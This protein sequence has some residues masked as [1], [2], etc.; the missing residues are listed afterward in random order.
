MRPAGERPGS[1][2]ETFVALD[3]ETAD[4]GRDSACA[5]GIVRVENRRIVQSESRL[6]RPPRRDFVFTPI[7]GIRWDDVALAPRFD[8]VWPELRGLVEGA[9]FLAAHNA[10]FDRSV[11][12]ACCQRAGLSPPSIPFECTVRIARRVW[13]IRPT[14][15]PDV[16][17]ALD[18]RLRHHEARSDAE[19]CARIMIAALEEES[20]RRGGEGPP[21]E[22]PRFP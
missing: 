5:V 12:L 11:L 19:A 8:E 3:F 14:K 22:G 15:L 13:G 1:P 20:P 18:L 6:I 21:E 9:R 7:H 17:R 2:P 4:P 10:A 16:C